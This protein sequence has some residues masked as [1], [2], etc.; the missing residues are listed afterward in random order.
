MDEG[1]PDS[2]EPQL[3]RTR[4]E[5]SNPLVF[6]DVAVGGEVAG[7]IVFELYKDAVPKTAENFR[8]LCTGEAGT[9]KSTG[10]PLHFKGAPFHRIIKNF[11]I[12]GGD[13]SA[14]NGT[15]GESVY[16]EKFEDEGFALK[17]DRPGLLS[18]ANAGPNTNGSQFFITTVPTPH[19][20]G[21][22]VVFG[23]VLKGYGT[24][25]TLEAQEVDTGSN[26][27]LRECVIADCGE[28]PADADLAGIR[29]WAAEE[30]DPYPEWPDDAEVPPEQREVDFRLAAAEAIRAKGNALFKVGEHQAALQRYN[31][32]MHWLDPDSFE[33]GGPPPS[34]GEIQRLGLAFISPLLNRAACLLRLG[35]AEK[36]A[37]DC[38][39][40]LERVPAHAKALFRRGQA[41]L[42][43]KEWDAA[44]ADLA[45]AQ[46]A[47]PGDAGVRAELARACKLRDAAQQRERAAYKRMFA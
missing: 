39:R 5:A 22:H 30:G 41:R 13:F 35:R 2:A 6:F 37:Q 26:R 17:H 34:A 47:E 25:R 24:V 7:M 38:S 44:L 16:G 43:L 9:G 10:L 4:R 20:D 46:E 36:S 8:E 33:A 28:L 32:A 15:G 23:Q 29:T 45:A 12:Q 11:M 3:K 14:R 18:M 19:L 27:P 40:V 21:K 31:K 1:A 42:A